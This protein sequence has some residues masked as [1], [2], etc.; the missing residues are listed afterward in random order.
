[1]DIK[2]EID[3]Y[4]NPLCLSKTKIK[5][6]LNEV[7]K[8]ETDNDSQYLQNDLHHE[9]VGSRKK[10]EAVS[11]EDLSCEVFEPKAVPSPLTQIKTEPIPTKDE[12]FFDLNVKQQETQRCESSSHDRSTATAPE[13]QSS[14]DHNYAL[15]FTDTLTPTRTLA[16]IMSDD[17]SPAF[18]CS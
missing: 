10:Y 7:K 11:S 6:E 12:F 15:P 16:K 17:V 9:S 2:K 8:E 5:S 4:F 3:F 18:L 13:I 1:M 14:L